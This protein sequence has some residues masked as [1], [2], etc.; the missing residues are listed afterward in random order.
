MMNEH[1][2]LIVIYFIVFMSSFTHGSLGFGFPMISTPL[3]TSIMELPD[4]ISIILVPTIVLNIFS[5]KTCNNWAQISK[6]HF[7]FAILASVGS[8]IGAF[9]LL[10]LN[11]SWFKLVLAFLIMIYLSL[12]FIGTIKISGLDN[13]HGIG[14]TVFAITGGVVG[15][16]T[17]VMAPVLMV[18][19]SANKYDKNESIVF[20][21]LSFLLGKVAQ[22]IVFVLMGYYLDYKQLFV[23]L[24]VT[25]TGFYAGTA[26]QKMIN[27][28]LYFKIIKV[29][30]L[31]IS[32]ELLMQYVLS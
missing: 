5:I 14:N 4:A 17:N 22:I 28:D 11:L 8:L 6:K 10:I 31:L 30:L 26:I 19:S 20:M 2:L 18:F 9:L 27:H 21:N 16:I 7:S 25:L 12:D 32:L 13:K 1:E 3:L 15:G 29:V 24:V 23:I